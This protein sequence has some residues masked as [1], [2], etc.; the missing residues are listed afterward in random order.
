MAQKKILF[1][2]TV[3]KVPTVFAPQFEITFSED[4]T[5]SMTGVL[6]KKPQFTVEAYKMEWKHLSLTEMSTI[7]QIVDHGDNF[8]VYYP[9]AHHG[10]WRTDTFYVG[11]GEMDMGSIEENGEYYNSLSFNIVCI[12]PLPRSS[13]SSSS[14]T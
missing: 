4:S 13:S 9:S 5:R 3:V 12:N 7:L 10:E 8:T 2:N 14:S 6:Y 1:N 11:R